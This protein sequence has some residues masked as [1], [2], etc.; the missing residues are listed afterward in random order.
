MT[1]YHPLLVALHWIMVLLILLALAAGGLMLSEMPN[2][3]P[4]KVDSLAGHMTV[5]LLIGSLLVLRFVT[6]LTTTSPPP[7]QTGSA[8]L[9]RVGALTH[10][11]FYILIAGM[12]VS[13]LATA[14][15]ADLFA[16]VFGG[17]GTPLPDSFDHLPQ[18]AAHGVIAICLVALIALHVVAAIYHQFILS[19][20]L[21][22]RMW[23]GKRK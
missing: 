21:L 1:R 7:A 8:L 6:R 4:Q 9:D 3:D 22:H 16:I 17:S 13:G 15:G 10:W 12:V 23:F 11:I 2:D 18:R 20:G 5:G 19:D 14:I